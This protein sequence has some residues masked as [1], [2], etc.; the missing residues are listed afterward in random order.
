[1]VS[2]QPEWL[3]DGLFQLELDLERVLARREPGSVAD[4]EDVRV[5][6]E[7]LFMEGGIQDDIGGLAA[8][9]RQFL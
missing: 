6:R 4:P 8:D 2:I 3:R 9:A 1:M 5:H 7:R